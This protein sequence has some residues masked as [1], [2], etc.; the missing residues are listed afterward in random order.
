MIRKSLVVFALAIYLGFNNFTVQAA[1]VDEFKLIASNAAADALFGASASLDGD[2]VIVGARFSGSRDDPDAA[3]IFERSG[4]GFWSEQA[5]LKPTDGPIDGFGLSVSIDGDTAVVGAPIDDDAGFASGSAYV[6]VR[7]GNVWTEQ[8]KLTASDAQEGDRFGHAVSIDAGTVIVGAPSPEAG[9]PDPGAAYIFVREGTVWT[10]EQKLTGAN[11]NAGDRFGSSVAVEGDTAI[12]GAPLEDEAG[13]DAGSVS[14]FTR[15]G[16]VW[17]QEQKLTA[18]DPGAFDHF[19]LSVSLSANT[20]L[21]GTPETATHD[22]NVGT[23]FAYVFVREDGGWSQQAKLVASDAA[24]DKLVGL[25]VALEGDTAVVAALQ[26]DQPLG[27]ASDTFAYIFV[28]DEDDWTEEEKLVTGSGA[29]ILTEGSF[30]DISGCTVVVG[31][32]LD[33]DAGMDAGAAYAYLIDECPCVEPVS[34]LISWWPLDEIVSP[35]VDQ[36]STNNGVWIDAPV[37]IAGVVDGALSFDPDDGIQV[38]HDPSLNFGAEGDFTM[39]AWIRPTTHLEVGTIVTKLDPATGQG[40]SL[41]L[42]DGNLAFVISDGSSAALSFVGDEIPLDVWSFVAVTV[43]RGANVGIVYVNGVE[44]GTFTPSDTATGSTDNT[45]PLFIASSPD[46]GRYVGDIDEVEIFDRALEPEQ[47]ALLYNVLSGGKCKPCSEPPDG[48]V[49]WW[50]FDETSGTISEDFVGPNDGEHVGGPVPA[51]G[52]VD[53]ALEFN[54]IDQR[55]KVADDPSLNFGDATSFSI[56]GWI[57]PEE[58]ED[59]VSVIVEKHE[60]ESRVGY[61]LFMR[62]GTLVFDMNDGSSLLLSYI[63][64]NVIPESWT[65]V[66]VTVDRDN[67]VGTV[68]V[69]GVVDGTFVPS[70]NV[71]DSISNT[72]PMFIAGNPQGENL[73]G[74]VDELEIYDRVL[75][76]SEIH[77]L[78]VVGTAGKCRTLPG[79]EEGLPAWLWVVII[80]VL[81]A[82]AVALLLRLRQKPAEG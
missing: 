65:F 37:S 52:K 80:A 33:D 3:Y 30:V 67:D 63:S 59:L 74:R 49:S 43:D 77:D 71:T 40:Y 9:S 4:V 31:T 16:T 75:A 50:L 76:D 73:R 81:L 62:S 36:I 78:Y 79:F 82:I 32:E 48:I 53:G 15:S 44:V 12:V 18:M 26:Y 2:T 25:S 7:S 64:P 54:G 55:V 10:E 70:D 24:V 11:G 17:S 46:H 57:R 27:V 69:D 42:M 13:D 66:A 58:V 5:I 6:F 21:I 47:I 38:P 45:E 1:P 68:Y 61:R 51:N 14:V 72:F 35:S 29:S 28:R 20:V 41:R 8:E 34:G 19:G 60:P 23:G 39:D 22:S 56:D